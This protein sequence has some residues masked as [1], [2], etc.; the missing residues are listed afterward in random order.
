MSDMFVVEQNLF[1]ARS[2]HHLAANGA[3]IIRRSC[4]LEPSR[5]R[6]Q[7]RSRIFATWLGVRHPQSSKYLK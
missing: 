4:P 5:L 2:V 1:G 6:C 7:T 3:A